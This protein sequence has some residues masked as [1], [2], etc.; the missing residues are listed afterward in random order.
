MTTSGIRP[1]KDKLKVISDFQQPKNIKELRQF[2]GICTYYRQFTIKH[3]T[4]LDPFREILRDKNP[5]EWTQNHSV[6]F[7]TMK[8]AFVDSIQLHHYIPGVP[9]KLQTDASDAGISGVL[10]QVDENGDHRIVSLVS[11]CLNAAEINYTTTEKELLAIVY[12]V[13]K[14]RTYLL[15][16]RFDVITDHK[17]LTF[18][19]S[20]SYLNARMIRWSITLQQYDFVVSHCQG[21]DNIVADFFSRNPE[22]KFESIK[23]PNLSIDVLGCSPGDDNDSFCLRNNIDLK[24]NLRD[25]LKNLSKLQR[26]DSYCQEIYKRIEID[27]QLKFYSLEGGVLLE[28]NLSEGSWQVIIPTEITRQ[29]IDNIHSKLGHPGIFKTIKYIQRFYHCKSMDSEIKR[30]VSSCDLCQRVKPINF[31]MERSYNRVYSSGPNDIVCVDFYGP[32]PRSTGGVEY[33]F[34]ILDAFIKYV[35][36]YSVRKENTQTILRKLFENYIPEMGKPRRV[37]SDH[38]TQFISPKWNQKLREEDIQVVYSS[39]RHPQSNPVER[40]MRELG[41]L[42]R[43]LCSDKHTKWAKYINDIEFFLNASTHSSTGFSPH[44]LHFGIQPA[45]QIQQLIRFPDTIDSGRTV[46]ICLAKENL[47]KSFERRAKS[48]K[49]PSKLELNEGDLVLLHVPKLSD[50]L[51]KVTRKFFHIYYGPYRIQRKFDNNAY[52][53]V[54]IDRDKKNMGIHN[55]VNL[56][57]YVRRVV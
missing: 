56:K 6:A 33:M 48:Q 15:G 26:R 2:I 29:L 38:G 20:T 54:A 5:W 32:L 1:L 52:E 12:S 30:F 10:Y 14:L 35:K 50:A 51:K 24:G 7:Q 31:K 53:L 28:K 45:D 36:L 39:I 11:R 42:F 21:K 18:L 17:A 34:V 9:Y 3:A 47:Q 27:P 8:D 41:R 23:S 44:E 22:G 40:V 13:S 25:S 46:K 43:T 16:T 19:S 37:L 55:H 57:K 4:L 49:S